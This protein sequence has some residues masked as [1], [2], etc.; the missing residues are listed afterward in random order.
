M[1][2]KAVFLDRDCTILE[3]GLYCSNPGDIKLVPDV[4]DCLNSLHD[5]GYLVILITNQSGTDRR[6][7][8]EDDHKIIHNKMLADLS[9]GGAT[10]DNI[11][12]CPHHPAE[13][14]DCLKPD[15]GMIKQAIG[16]YSFFIGDKCPAIE[17]AVRAGLKTVL[18]PSSFPE[19][20]ELP[21]YR[22]ASSGQIDF[23]SNDFC[24]AVRWIISN[25]SRADD[26][27][28]IVPTM[29]EEQNLPHVLPYLPRDAE[30]IIVDGHSSDK[31]I[32][33]AKKL[34]PDAVIL[35]Q[36]GRGKGNAMRY[37]FK[38]AT[39]D[40]IITYDGDGSFR[41]EEIDPMLNSLRDGFDLVKGSRF[42]PNGGTN[43]M[44][45][46]RR[47]GNR[48][49]TM[50]TN[51]FFGTHYTDLVYGLHGF[52]RELLDKVEFVSDGFEIDTEMYIKTKING[53]KVKEVP[54]F[55]Q[56]RIHGVGKLS[57]L[58]DG[59]RILKTILRVRFSA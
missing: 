54:S 5:S 15:N 12:C 18:V 31:T 33:V 25:S 32:E 23:V 17:S 3:D 28:I 47:V 24:D 2:N 16:D 1:P 10:I 7:F 58:S 56:E 34:R 21:K 45:F 11:Y 53:Y 41:T 50:L 36:P 44:P 30:I 57:T 59:W 42:L 43:D 48:G 46:L 49:F 55:E 22:D 27:S 39:R 40:L 6:C 20:E 19:F 51:L 52:R 8:S 13:H 26:L 4:A 35:V 37:G 38:H 9:H 14:C 29:N